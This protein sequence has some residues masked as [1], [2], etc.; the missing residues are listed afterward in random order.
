M[1]KNR[2]IKLVGLAVLPVTLFSFEMEFN[3]KFTQELMADTL[4]ANIIIRIDGKEEKI[5]SKKLTKFNDEIKEN[6]EVER[7]LGNFTVRPSYKY[8]STNTPKIVGYIGELR[9]SINST[10]AQNINEFISNINNLKESRD[11]SI[12][13][14]GLSWKVKD[15]TYDV[16]LDILRLQAINW[17]E[18]YAANLSQE[19]QKGCRVQN[20]RIN[21]PRNIS[22]LRS[23]YAME[24]MSS[25]KRN[26]PVPKADRQ[27]L[28]INP[29]YKLECK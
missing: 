23:N 3:K 10:N 9:Y 12:T 4:S 16:A 29:T 27:K 21:S 17:A 19:L 2:L 1:I 8:S 20:I 7:K 14:S 25:S 5:I 13:V 24:A 6:D 18:V 15:S 11:T 26:V 22:P 28:E